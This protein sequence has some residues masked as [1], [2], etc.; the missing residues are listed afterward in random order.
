MALVLLALRFNLGREFAP[1]AAA[2]GDFGGRRKAIDG[3]FRRLD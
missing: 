2:A 3:E 1:R